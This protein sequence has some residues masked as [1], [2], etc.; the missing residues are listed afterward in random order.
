M[1]KHHL[2]ISNAKETQDELQ[3][4]S[5][6]NSYIH[7]I[8]KAENEEDSDETGENLDVNTNTSR[9]F[10][11]DYAK[12]FKKVTKLFDKYS[13]F[14]INEEDFKIRGEMGNGEEEETESEPV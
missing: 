2:K 8:P 1:S 11:I 13:D 3:D 10:E 7:Y 14:Y 6:F 12:I 4:V 5:I 9:V